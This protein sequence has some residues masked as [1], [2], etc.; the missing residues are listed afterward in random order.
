[1]ATVSPSPPPLQVASLQPL[2]QEHVSSLGDGVAAAA[3]DAAASLGSLSAT[4]VAVVQNTA[5]GV[6]GAV[7]GALGGLAASMDGLQAIAA[8]T[9]EQVARQG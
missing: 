9:A 7:N 3:N 4:S 1:M 2:V 8:E 5:E 6:G